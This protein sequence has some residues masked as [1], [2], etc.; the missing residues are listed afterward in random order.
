MCDNHPDIGGLRAGQLRIVA[1][2]FSLQDVVF[3]SLAL[4]CPWPLPFKTSF[5]GM[6]KIN[7][8]RTVPLT[9]GR[10]I[11]LNFYIAAPSFSSGNPYD[12][13][14]NRIPLTIRRTRVHTFIAPLQNCNGL[15]CS[16][17]YPSS[18]AISF[19]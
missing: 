16:C 17:A 13:N 5:Y 11:T 9:I 10:F 3:N 15:D 4:Q 8:A 1:L 6:R 7:A 19:D 18:K 14:F 12:V 2:R